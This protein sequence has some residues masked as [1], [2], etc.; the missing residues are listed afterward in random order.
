V[1]KPVKAHAK[2]ILE[3]EIRCSIWLSYGAEFEKTYTAFPY[4]SKRPGLRDFDA[5]P[6]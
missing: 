4:E 2:L 1:R 6:P 3:L 5:E